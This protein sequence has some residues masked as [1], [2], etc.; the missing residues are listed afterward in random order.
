MMGH[1][2]YEWLPSYI[3]CYVTTTTTEIFYELLNSESKATV[4]FEALG[5][6]PPVTHCNIP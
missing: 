2:G 5:T 4:T 3:P 6:M 1:F